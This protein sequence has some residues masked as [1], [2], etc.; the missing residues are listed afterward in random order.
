MQFEKDI[1]RCIDIL[2]R[3]GLI[4]YPT[5]TVWGIGCDAENGQAVSKIFTL[6]QRAETKAMIILLSDKK[7]I[8]RYVDKPK[9]EIID[10][11]SKSSNP[12]TAIYKYGKN[13]ATNLIGDDGSIAIRIVN[14]DFCKT[15]IKNFKKPLVSTS[16]NISGESTPS[17]FKNISDQIKNG[18]DYIVQHRQ[19]DFTIYKPSSIIKLNDEGVIE[20]LRK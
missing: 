20:I 12:I 5:D 9:P 16:A 14:D 1:E 8:E 4:L 19:N 11:V 10:Y 6:K 13:V 2:K 3:G 18:V 17:I 15:L 7:D